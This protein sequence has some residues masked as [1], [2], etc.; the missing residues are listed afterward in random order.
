MKTP[1]YKQ[2]E[3][4][5][6][7]SLGQR[8]GDGL[9]HALEALAPRGVSIAAGEIVAFDEPLMSGEAR[10]T[11]NAVPSRQ[12]EFRAGRAAARLAMT[13]LGVAPSAIPSGPDRAPRWPRGLVGSIS[14]AHGHVTA[15]IA[16][17]RSARALGIDIEAAAPLA[18]DVAALVCRG[19][20]GLPCPAH[21]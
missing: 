21:I 3:R 4:R 15:A 11:V 8:T 16:H 5:K 7:V 17:E 12:L 18:P 1:T 9:Q 19:S 10:F 13:K 20:E 6:R 14:H 2:L